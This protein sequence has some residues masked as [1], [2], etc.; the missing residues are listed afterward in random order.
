MTDIQLCFNKDFEPIECP[1]LYFV[2]KKYANSYLH[3]ILYNGDDEHGRPIFSPA[4]PKELS[5]DKQF[6]NVLKKFNWPEG[7]FS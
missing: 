7:N 4:N 6:K 1:E 5:K 3:S 2:P